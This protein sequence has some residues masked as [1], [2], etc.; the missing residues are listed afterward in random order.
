MMVDC[1]HGNSLK[2]HKNQPLVA[3]TLAEQIEKGEEGVMGVMIESNIGEGELS[4]EQLTLILRVA[5]T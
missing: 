2:N 3:A 4:H 5:N 1:S